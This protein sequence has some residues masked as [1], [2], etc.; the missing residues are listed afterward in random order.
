MTLSAQDILNCQDSGIESVSVPEWGGD[1][2]I[3]TMTGVERDNWEVYAS[4]QFEK[5]GSVNIRAKLAV[6]TLCDT[7]GNRLFK[8][9][10]LDQLS[11][12]NSKALDR[13]YSAALKLN[14]LTDDDI[15]DLEK[16]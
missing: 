14:K 1:V 7:S 13:V 8:D 5:K 12:K 10:D 11:G 6:L 4:S 3:R 9:S 16:N 15:E 2:H